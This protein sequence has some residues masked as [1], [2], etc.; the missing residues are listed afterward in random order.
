MSYAIN[1]VTT[2]DSHPRRPCSSSNTEGQGIAVREEVAR[3]HFG[4]LSFGQNDFR[5][6]KILHYI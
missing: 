2:G 5:V 1:K 3:G 4:H 6:V